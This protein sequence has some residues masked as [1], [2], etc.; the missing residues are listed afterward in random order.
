M[1]EQ[2]PPIEFAEA[3]EWSTWFI[4]NMLKPDPPFPDV[5]PED[6]NAPMY[7]DH[8]TIT[9]VRLLR[10][11]PNQFITD[12]QIV[13]EV[14]DMLAASVAWYS[15]HNKALPEPA[16]RWLAQFLKG[17]IQPPKARAGAPVKTDL[18]NAIAH[19]VWS[20]QAK[21]LTPTR[22]DASAEISG[23]DAVA[24]AL[25]N[26]KLSTRSYK[27]VKG[28]WTRFKTEQTSRNRVAE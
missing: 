9:G 2:Q 6:W 24:K 18:H 22:N 17:D 16:R 21:G 23:C 19:A 28:I 8:A 4:E 3:V 12:A 25:Q 5:D 20:L 14:W 11:N 10:S 15:D 26:L 7:L 1:T 27:S 13:R